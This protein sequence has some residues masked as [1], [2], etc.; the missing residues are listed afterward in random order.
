MNDM[1]TEDAGARLSEI[2]RLNCL[3]ICPWYS[4]ACARRGCGEG[5]ERSEM[6]LGSSG[7]KWI[8]AVK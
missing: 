4:V 2:A 7:L 3:D 8:T 5:N 1:S 6:L